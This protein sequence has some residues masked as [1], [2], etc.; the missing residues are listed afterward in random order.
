MCACFATLCMK[1]FVNPRTFCLLA[2]IPLT[3]IWVFARCMFFF[4]LCVKR[5]E[6]PKALYKFP[7]II[8]I[9][10]IHVP[11]NRAHLLK[12][13]QSIFSSNAC[14]FSASL[15]WVMLPFL[16]ETNSQGR[17]FGP[18]HSFPQSPLLDVFSRF[19]NKGSR[20]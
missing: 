1:F 10:I 5:F 14:L 3:C 7:I 13:L 20:S 11:A 4:K 6:S 9:I 18:I 19:S 8:I 17:R 15:N 16:A 2:Y 12:D